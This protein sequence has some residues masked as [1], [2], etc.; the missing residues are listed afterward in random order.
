MWSK[1]QRLHKNSQVWVTKVISCRPEEYALS[2]CLA[3]TCRKTN[4]ISLHSFQDL[5]SHII[6]L[7]K[8]LAGS[9]CTVLQENLVLCLQYIKDLI[10]F[11]SYRGWVH[12]SQMHMYCNGTGIKTLYNCMSFEFCAT[13]CEG[14]FL[15]FFVI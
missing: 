7:L 11:I 6:T 4:S 9:C 2:K 10:C 5:F 8:W 13:I 12:I 14:S 15:S 1:N 3:C